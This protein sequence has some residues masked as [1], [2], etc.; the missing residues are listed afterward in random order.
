M[1]AEMKVEYLVDRKESLTV[2]LTG[3][4]KVV[5]MVLTVVGHWEF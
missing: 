2:D 3:I 4:E 1:L 5:K